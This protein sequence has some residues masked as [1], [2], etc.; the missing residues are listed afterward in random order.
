MS[1]V[2]RVVGIKEHSSTTSWGRVIQIETIQ[3]GNL[4]LNNQ[5]KKSTLCD[6]EILFLKMSPQ[7]F[8]IDP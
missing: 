5:N 4:V 2:G 6:P 3:E 7:I 1:S 8:H